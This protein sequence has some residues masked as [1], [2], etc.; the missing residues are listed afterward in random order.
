MCSADTDLHPSLICGTPSERS[1]DSR[2]WTMNASTKMTVS[3]CGSGAGLTGRLGVG[4][5]AP[6]LAD[7]R[8]GVV[9]DGVR[10]GA[11]DGVGD[12]RADVRGGV[13]RTGR[14]AW[15]GLGTAGFGMG[16]SSSMAAP[17][18]AVI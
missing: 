11:R 2:V 14:A 5:G 13:T 9:R 8:V 4:R 6:G 10:T 16:A 7:G 15:F 17:G 1:D 3:L 18:H 12:L